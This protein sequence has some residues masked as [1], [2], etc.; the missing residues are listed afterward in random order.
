MV[1]INV[2]TQE[3]LIYVNILAQG[4]FALWKCSGTRNIWFMQEEFEDTRGAIRIRISKKKKKR[5]HNWQKKMYKGTNNDIQNKHKTKDRV[6]FNPLKTAG[7]L[8][9]SGRISS[10]CSN[11]DTRCVN[12]VTNQV[13]SH[14]WG[15]DREVLTTSGTYPR[16]LVRRY[17]IAVNQVMMATVKH[18]KW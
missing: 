8:R 17:S 3:Y 1:Y 2:L 14:A 9:C 16:S 7:E 15:K 18:S 6:T 12:L 10:S 5:Q 13:I 11:S 4:I